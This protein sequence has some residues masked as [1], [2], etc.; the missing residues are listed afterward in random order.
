[1][2]CHGLGGMGLQ[3]TLCAPPSQSRGD[4][5]GTI[6]PGFSQGEAQGLRAQVPPGRKI[7]CCDISLLGWGTVPSPTGHS[8]AMA[9]SGTMTSDALR[10][11]DTG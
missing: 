9:P 4:R 2:W 6:R 11:G 3:G 1:M 8:P 5:S 7:C 10:V